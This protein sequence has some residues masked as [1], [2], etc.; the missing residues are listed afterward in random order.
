AQVLGRVSGRDDVVFGTVLMGRMQGGEGAARALGMFINTLPLRV[1]IGGQD[2]RAG[3][4]STHARLTALLGHEHASLAL[5]QRCSGVVAPA[6]LFS[7]LLN[8]RHTGTATSTDAVSAWNGIQVLGGE[9]R[10][11]YPL[12]LSVDDLGESFSLT[13]QAASGIDA[14]RICA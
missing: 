6:P 2:V 9:E 1:S 5:A 4:K 14:P 11:N 13:V 3:V 7:A 12:M 10:T 8:Y